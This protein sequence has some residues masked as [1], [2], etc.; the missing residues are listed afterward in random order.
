MTVVVDTVSTNF[1]AFTFQRVRRNRHQ[2]YQGKH[3]EIQSMTSLVTVAKQK[4][5][6][7]LRAD[8]SVNL[9]GIAERMTDNLHHMNYHLQ[10][11]LTQKLGPDARHIIVAEGARLPMAEKMRLAAGFLNHHQ[12]HPADEIAAHL[13]EVGK[14]TGDELELLVEYRQYYAA[15]LADLLIVKENLAKLE[16]EPDKGEKNINVGW[17]Q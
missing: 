12:G 11:L 2:V 14:N 15:V 13:S 16:K 10:K 7:A 9:H 17:S 6:E 4:T 3:S 8:R 1:T 5:C